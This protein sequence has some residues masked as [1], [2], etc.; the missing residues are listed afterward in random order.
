MTDSAFLTVKQAA[1]FLTM[2]QAWLFASDIPHVKLGRRRL[3]RRE[4]L[5]A[6]V[7]KKVRR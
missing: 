4:D 7:A 3:Y 1:R 6:Y 5:I 2:S